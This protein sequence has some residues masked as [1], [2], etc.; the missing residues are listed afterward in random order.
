M[1]H[2]LHKLRECIVANDSKIYARVGGICVIGHSCCCQQSGWLGT[3]ILTE[4]RTGQMGFVFQQGKGLNP[5][6]HSAQTG[7]VHNTDSYPVGSGTLYLASIRRNVKMTAQCSAKIKNA[8]I[9]FSALPYVFVRTW[10][11]RSFVAFITG[12][13]VILVSGHNLHNAWAHMWKTVDLYSSVNRLARGRAEI[14]FVATSGPKLGPLTASYRVG[15]G[16]S[17]PGV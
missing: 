8:R 2:K 12:V 1:V 6:P 4:L 5:P 9:Y 10:R 17:A 14:V 11:Y 7:S 13:G 3:S 15:I 16:V